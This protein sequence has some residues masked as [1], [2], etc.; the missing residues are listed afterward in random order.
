MSN[1][2]P[3]RAALLKVFGLDA[4]IVSASGF[5]LVDENGR[6]YLDFL[7]QYGA[8]PF[9]HNPPALWEA[10]D[11]ARR[12]QMPSLVQPMRSVEAERLA[13][14]LAEITPGDLSITT[15][16]NSGAETVEAAIKLAR[17]RTGRSGILSTHNGFHGKT[18]GALSAT[19]KPQY[20]QGF[21]APAPGFDYVAYGD[22]QALKARLEAGGKDIAAFIV[23]PIQGEGGVI[24]PPSDYID[25]AIALC[26]SHGVLFILDEIQTGLGRT[27]A[28]FACSNGAEL[29]DMLL[30]AKALGGGMMPIGACIVRP[31]AWDD[32]FGRLHSSTFANNNLA[33]KIANASLDILLKD[34]QAL[35]KQVAKNGAYLREQLEALWARYPEVI[36]EVR[37][38]GYMVGL[39]FHRFDSRE[40]SATMAFSS[41]NGGVTPLI[42]SYLLN[43]HGLLTAP[44]FNETHVMRLQ[45]TLIVGRAE[46]DRAIAALEAVCAIVDARDYYALVKHLVANPIPEAGRAPR[47][48]ETSTAAPIANAQSGQFAFLVHYTEQEDIFRSDPSFRQFSDDELTNW[49]AWVKQLGPG[50]ARNIPKVK[51]KTGAEAEG[52]IMSVPMLPSDMRGAGRSAATEMIKDAVDLAVGDGSGRVGLGAFTS[53][54]TRGGEMATGRG[55]AITSGNTLTT[56]SAVKGIENVARR[57]GLPLQDAH[58]VVIG[59]AGAI[60]RLA[61]LMLARRVGRVSLVGNATNPFT[62]KLLSNTADEVYEMLINQGGD[63]TYSTGYAVERVQRISASWGAVENRNGLADRITAAFQTRGEMPPVDYTSSLESA[64]LDADIVLVATSSDKSL[65]DPTELRPGTLVCDIARPPNVADATLPEQSVLI[66]DGG[67][68]QPPFELDLGAFQTLPKNLCW[69]CLGETLLLTLARETRDY[70]IGSRLSLAD[71][72]HLSDL[73]DLHG[74]VPAPT[75]WY[76][77]KVSDADI[78][79]FSRHVAGAQRSRLIENIHAAQ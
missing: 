55:A 21:A 66:F 25:A 23:E 74:F 1:L 54:V 22:I 76:G 69:G 52:W 11:A 33:C 49:C 63:V 7:S 46:I 41:I 60:G 17:M 10:F 75:Q 53:I 57:A 78:E 50:F 27:G 12:A 68:V 36:R 6:T 34:D 48:A 9:G 8:L 71:A 14:R 47:S 40:D 45:P 61:S 16:T 37:G 28:L 35:I 39:E 3:A 64:L 67:L 5:D 77:R 2:N 42:S 30:L 56:I 24:C 18:L 43:V 26:R 62:P 38:R 44:L 70:S 19:G 20:Q 73:A 65:I 58:V 13:D 4:R 51:S 15:L 79:N 31:S 29:P 72:D 59:A 32:R